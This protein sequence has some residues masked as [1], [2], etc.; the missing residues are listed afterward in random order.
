MA[1]WRP[2][3]R[4]RGPDIPSNP[5]RLTIDPCNKVVSRVTVATWR[6]RFAAKR[7]DGL[8]DEPRPGAPRRIGDEKI[9][10][11]V[12]TTLETMPAA[13]THWSTRSMAKASGLS[14]STVHRIWRAF[15]LQP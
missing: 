14:V 11:V 2:S 8:A 7:L 15:S 13:A 9:A 5:R 12:T 3:V 1:R 10:E 4:K 6:Q